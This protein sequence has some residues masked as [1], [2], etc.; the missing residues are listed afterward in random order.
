[1]VFF[2]QGVKTKGSQRIL[3]FPVPLLWHSK[4]AKQHRACR[5][6]KKSHH[7]SICAIEQVFRLCPSEKEGTEECYR[8]LPHTFMNTFRRNQMKTKKI[9]KNKRFKCLW[10]GEISVGSIHS[11]LS[12]D[13]NRFANVL[14]ALGGRREKKRSNE[15]ELQDFLLWLGIPIPIF[16]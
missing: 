16:S 3:T 15:K 13:Q 7:D 8:R 4:T 12:T 1:M 11:S 6:E 5:R 10:K 2:L 9:K 14:S